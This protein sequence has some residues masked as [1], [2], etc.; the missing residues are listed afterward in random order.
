M[1]DLR[2]DFMNFCSFEKLGRKSVQIKSINYFLIPIGVMKIMTQM[3]DQYSLI[4]K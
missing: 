4:K 2:G 1:R 3:P